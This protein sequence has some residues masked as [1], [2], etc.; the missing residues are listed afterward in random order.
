MF[1]CMY[2]YEKTK[3]A[4]KVRRRDGER[5]RERVKTFLISE[6]HEERVFFAA[7]GQEERKGKINNWRK[8]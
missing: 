5:E 6:F 4:Q 1:K 3:S 2:L 8:G 7:K